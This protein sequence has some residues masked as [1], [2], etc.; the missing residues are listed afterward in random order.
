[1][2]KK[3]TQ[4]QFEK[5]VHEKYPNIEIKGKYINGTTK[6]DCRCVID[7]YTWSVIP[8]SVLKHGCPV[9]SGHYMND[10][11]FKE[12]MK[13]VNIKVDVIGD[14]IDRN[15]PVKCKC[16]LCGDIFMGNVGSLLNGSTHNDCKNNVKKKSKTHEWFLNQINNRYPN[17]YIFLTKYTKKKSSIKIKHIKCGYEWCTTP[18]ALL[19]SKSSHAPC[20]KCSNVYHYSNQEYQEKLKMVNPTIIPLEEY[21][22]SDTKILHQ[23]TVCGY[24]WKVDT[25]SLINSH[26]GCPMCKGGT[27]TIIRG[28]NDMWTTNPELASLLANPEDGY[29]YSQG[30][31][32]KTCFKCKNCGT[33]SKPLS[34]HKV[35]TRG[36]NCKSCSD[37][38]SLPNR[39]MYNILS[40]L[41]INFED[42]KK[43]EW[44]KFKVNE[45]NRIGIYDFYINSL[46]LI[47]E[48]DGRFHYDFNNLSKQSLTTSQFIDLE[49]D[50]LAIEHGIKI[51]RIDCYNSDIDYI[52]EH[53]LNSELT[54][55]IN[56]KNINWNYCFY[57]TIPNYVKDIWEKY[58]NGVT[59]MDLSREY[60]KDYGTISKY[61]KMGNNM[62]KCNY[63]L[64][65][66]HT[67]V[68]CLDTLKVY[69]KISEAQRDTGATNISYACRSK[70]HI[71]GKS[72]TGHPLHWMYYKDYKEE[73]GEV[74]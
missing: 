44:C 54:N 57:H 30:T 16:L 70:T 11:A 48:M 73:F 58:N 47:I 31:S 68:I 20:P 40:Y 6:I 46:N 65:G 19:N 34:I 8:N 45:K 24:K 10:F 23:C 60:N 63:T 69:N 12:R 9:C 72:N 37:T 5:E 14:Y 25:N 26:R 18:D 74:S 64:D 28:V 52:K 29:K 36:F 50:R 53:I 22:N 59:I 2:A 4:E 62:G 43:F 55:Y 67:E 32:K 61:L 15:T 1:M 38:R 35:K 41:N 49:K 39:I 13:D 33:V 51:I 3:K 21:I 7:N 27:N 17:E 56:L 71:A 42:E 66:Y